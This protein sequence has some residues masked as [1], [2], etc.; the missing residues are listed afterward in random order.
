M[1][2]TA[3]RV[4]SRWILFVIKRWWKTGKW[5]REVINA[6]VKPVPSGSS[7]FID[8]N[9]FPI[10][11]SSS[12]LVKSSPFVGIDDFGVRY[13]EMRMRVVSL[14]DADL[15]AYVAETINPHSLRELGKKELERRLER[16]RIVALPDVELKAY[17]HDTMHLK[18]LRFDGWLE[19]KKRHGICGVY[20][21]DI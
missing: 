6:E 19:L 20:L 1:P 9:K 14:N 15:K 16:S 18:S 11:Y 2:L 8:I 4:W 17:V 7:S 12:H 3:S 13:A 21:E 5:K 10:N